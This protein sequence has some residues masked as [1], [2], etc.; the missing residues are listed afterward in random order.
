MKIGSCIL[1]LDEKYFRKLLLHGDGRYDIK[2]NES[3]ILAFKLFIT[4]F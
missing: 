4:S 2:K 3:I 1:T